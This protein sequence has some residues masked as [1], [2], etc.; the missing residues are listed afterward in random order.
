MHKKNTFSLLLGLSLALLST[1]CL[2]QTVPTQGPAAVKT[3]PTG[4]PP[5]AK[6]GSTLPAA[7]PDQP[8]SS[9]P[10]N[11]G[12]NN[13]P[14]VF[15]E[16][17][18]TATQIA[19]ISG[20]NAMTIYQMAEDRTG[21]LHAV[22]GATEGLWHRQMDKN[23]QWSD[24]YKFPTEAVRGV[25][26]F[27]LLN[28]PD[29]KVC[30]LWF[31]R[32]SAFQLSCL[33]EGKWT[34]ASQDISQASQPAGSNVNNVISF[35]ADFGPDGKLQIIS[36]L[37]GA[38]LF[39]G[40]NK[41]FPDED[42]SK[43][44]TYNFGMVKPEKYS[45]SYYHYNSAD[46][47]TSWVVKTSADRGKSWEERKFIP[48]PLFNGGYANLQTGSDEYLH[49]MS[50][51]GFTKVNGANK[52]GAW[53]SSQG[54]FKCEPFFNKDEIFKK[55]M[56]DNRYLDLTQFSALALAVDP[57]GRLHFVANNG[58]SGLYHVILEKDNSWNIQKIQATSGSD[59]VLF[60]D[61]N[62]HV[63]IIWR[64][65]KGLFFARQ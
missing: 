55:A 59:P 30:V 27:K 32:K 2:A 63:N 23:G 34:S 3:D 43:D 62:G 4:R 16:N 14:Y 10:A 45:L 53:I 31:E 49:F 21:T 42:T 50:L 1:A 65:L 5:E 28:A 60:V 13:F 19:D 57:K 52:F 39:M 38:G 48:D 7:P 37:N 29:G 51:S 35:E 54:A 17:L 6:P 15:S 20:I 47:T 24:P 64:T 58:G 41:L 12:G 18:L 11:P 22:W 8:K 36:Y 40:N 44:L 46:K 9:A 33:A 61:K 25:D 26:G 56:K